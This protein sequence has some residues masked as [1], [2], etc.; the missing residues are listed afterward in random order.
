MQFLFTLLVILVT[1]VPTM[2]PAKTVTD[3][4]GRSV[5]V[6]D[7]PQR[8]ISL[9]DWTLTVM[10]RELDAPLIASNGRLAADGSTFMRGARELFGLD[11]TQIALASI[12]GKADLERIRSLKPDLIVANAG[13]YSPLADQLTSIAPTLM[14]NPENG[15]PGFELYREFAAW[16]G[17]TDRFNELQSAY[18]NRIAA[19]KSRLPPAAQT[20][21]YAAILTNGRDGTL[22]ILKEYGPLTEVLDD[23]GLSRVPLIETVPQGQ[24]RMT[25]GAELI[26]ELDADLIV[27][28]YLPETG[29]NEQS[30]FDDLDAIAPGYRDFLLAYKTG[31]ILSFSRYKVYPPSFRGADILLD[32]LEQ[33]WK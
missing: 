30:V 26:G 9:H 7:R 22:T 8:I 32:E 6:P 33:R 3:H 29:S 14:F 10:A 16:I 20:A 28:S 17:R 25:I 11:F 5:E 15:Q 24:S 12:H 4:E 21:S 19:L 2:A 18:R 31:S 23:L 13:D 1:L 27:T